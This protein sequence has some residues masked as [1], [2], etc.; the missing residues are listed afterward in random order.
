MWRKIYIVLQPFSHFTSRRISTCKTAHVKV[1]SVKNP[2]IQNM[3]TWDTF[4]R[5]FWNCLRLA[6]MYFSSYNNNSF[7]HF[8]PVWPQLGHKIS[9]FLFWKLP[10]KTRVVFRVLPSWSFMFSSCSL[11]FFDDINHQ[12][13]WFCRQRAPNGK[14]DWFHSV[15]NVA[16]CWLRHF[17]RIGFKLGFQ[18]FTTRPLLARHIS[19][20]FAY[21][22]VQIVDIDV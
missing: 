15:M 18:K 2:C 5:Y 14:V 8:K 3:K 21:Q 12:L 1:K 7:T 6:G 17:R 20:P 9:F 11:T 19:Y 22:S 16:K 13:Y 4:H 10:C